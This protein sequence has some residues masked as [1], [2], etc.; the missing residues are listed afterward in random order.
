MPP[1]PSPATPIRRSSRALVA[2]VALVAAWLATAGPADAEVPAG[3]TES[4]VTAVLPHTPE[5]RVRVLGGDETVRLDVSPG[6]EVVI[7]GYQ[8][9]PY[10]RIDA[11][12]TVWENTRSPAVGANASR[13]S[14][15][16]GTG[17]DADA[18]PSWV[19]IGT[20]GS[21]EWHDHRTHW[22]VESIPVPGEPGDVVFPWTIDLQVDGTPVQVQ[23][24]L[25][26][27]PAVVVWPWFVLAGAVAAAVL[28]IGWQR[29]RSWAADTAAGAALAAAAGATVVLVGERVALECVGC[30]RPVDA[31][32]VLVAVVAAVVA[33]VVRGGRRLVATGL[34]LVALTGWLVV[35][36][37]AL[38]EPVVVSALDAT[39]VRVLVAAELG[40]VVGGL[41]LVAQAGKRQL[42]AYASRPPAARRRTPTTAATR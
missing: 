11:D 1:A 13:F 5:V 6:H 18:E 10:R 26:R 29:G 41:V 34:A 22:M 37:R 38:T 9:E 17:A 19:A 40:L 27:G 16:G 25:R 35:H 33:L 2:L 30:G 32:P 14:T 39:L 7:A 4:V 36:L 8:G 20:G 3:D 21:T 24:E 42:D 12:G 31:V 15:G 23:G 28:A